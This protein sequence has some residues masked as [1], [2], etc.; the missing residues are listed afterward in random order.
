MSFDQAS[1]IERILAAAGGFMVGG[2]GSAFVGGTFGYKEMAKSLVLN[3]AVGLVLILG[4]GVI[5]PVILIPALLGTGLVQNLWTLKRSN[6]KIVYEIA[7]QIAL[8]LMTKSEDIAD[9]IVEFIEKEIMK[10][11]E[12]IEQG[13]AHEINSV[14]EQVEVAIKE[15]ETGEAN[16]SARRELLKQIEQEITVIHQDLS[17]LLLLISI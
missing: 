8:E 7:N 15:K 6:D 11:A 12:P 10:I 17:N 9:K 2:I 3:M 14:R 16:A 4:L 1:G 13:M 5:N